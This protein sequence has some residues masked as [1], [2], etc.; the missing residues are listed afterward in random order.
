MQTVFN[1]SKTVVSFFYG[2]QAFG[3]SAPDA[4]EFA[5]QVKRARHQ[6]EAKRVEKAGQIPF[7]EWAK[8]KAVR[9]CGKSIHL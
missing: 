4:K 5:E 6:D 3:M 7:A 2:K 8:W 9:L 1:R